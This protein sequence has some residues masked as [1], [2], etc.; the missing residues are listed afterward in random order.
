MIAELDTLIALVALAAI[1]TGI[2]IL[3]GPAAALI[4]GGLAVITALV[5]V[6]RG[7]S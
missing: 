4:A 6:K 1:V 5:L 3:L 7:E 2:G